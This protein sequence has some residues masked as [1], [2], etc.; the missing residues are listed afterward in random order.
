MVFLWKMSSAPVEASFCKCSGVCS[1]KDG[2]K[3]KGCP[4]KTQGDYCSSSCKCLL[5]GKK[6]DTFIFYTHCIG[7]L[8]LN[9]NWAS[10]SDGCKNKTTDFE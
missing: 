4:C 1:R 5:T 8:V 6:W 10:Q 7:N 3:T 2:R 9:Y